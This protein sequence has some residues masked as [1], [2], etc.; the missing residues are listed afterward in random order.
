[1]VKIIYINERDSGIGYHRLQVPFANMDEDYKDLNIKGTNGF[2]LEFHPKQFDIV[3]LNRMYKHDEDYLLKAKQSGCKIILDIDDWIQLPNYHYKDGIKDTIV[4]S[5]I[6]DAIGYADV[7]WT[8]SEY[9]KECLFAYHS[10]IVYVPNAIDFTQP[11]FIPNKQPQDKYTIGWIGANNHHLDLKKMAEPFAKLLKNKNHKLLL[12]GYN[13]TSKEYYELIEKYFTT[14]YTRPANQYM[15]VEW[16]DI[17]NYALMYN[18]MDC[19][20]APLCND[21]FSQCKSNLKVLEAGAFSLPIICSNVEPYIE[22]IKEGLV[23]N[24]KGDWDGAMKSLISNP[25]KGV[26]LGARLHEYVKENYNI[27]KINQIRYESINS[28]MG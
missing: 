17:R 7:I 4:E 24:P 12:G 1:M 23:I 16:M 10:N 2:T 3:V 27:K 13:D 15:R 20:I 18:L 19:A 6:L 22:F 25:K 9:L 5:R 11:Q 8:A 21:K 26:E 14:N 28:I